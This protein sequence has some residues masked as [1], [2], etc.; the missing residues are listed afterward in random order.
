MAL[1]GFR[2]ALP[3][4][5]LP[6][7]VASNSPLQCLPCFFMLPV[8]I[9]AQKSLGNPIKCMALQKKK[10]ADTSAAGAGGAGE[11]PFR[12]E[13]AARPEEWSRRAEPRKRHT[14][15]TSCSFGTLVFCRRKCR[16]KKTKDQSPLEVLM[17]PRMP[18]C[19]PHRK[20]RPNLLHP[21]SCPLGNQRPCP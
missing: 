18:H 15:G 10:L 3:A 5:L 8:G 1:P 19:Q 14:K 4:P 2:G 6:Q 17:L 9:G 12:R 7:R 20:L 13:C 11:S 16:P 21:L